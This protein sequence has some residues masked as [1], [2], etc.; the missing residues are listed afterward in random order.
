[1]GRSGFVISLTASAIKHR[2]GCEVYISGPNAKQ[3]YRWL[4]KDKAEIEE[5]TG[6]LEWQELPEGQDCR[7]VQYRFDSDVQDWSKR[8]DAYEWLLKQ[9]ELFHRT[10]LPIIV[11]LP[12]LKTTNR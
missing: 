11:G 4:E 7:I 1:M 3:A 8:A 2:L 6:P 9:A 12:S 5:A 10:V